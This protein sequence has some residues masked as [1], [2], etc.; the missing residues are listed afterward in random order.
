[1]FQKG[2]EEAIE[3]RIT[4]LYFDGYS[5][6][7]TLPSLKNW[8]ENEELKGSRWAYYIKAQGLK[9]GICGFDKDRPIA[10]EY[11]KKHGIPY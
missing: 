4:G 3:T 7:Q 2:K 5:G 1:L 11:I 6:E 9:Y 8:I 10:I